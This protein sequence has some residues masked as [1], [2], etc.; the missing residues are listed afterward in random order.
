M[1]EK[2]QMCI[3]KSTGSKIQYNLLKESYAVREKNEER[4][5]MWFFFCLF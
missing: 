3:N 5:P 2:L 1:E 4:G